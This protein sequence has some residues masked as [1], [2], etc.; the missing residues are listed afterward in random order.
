VGIGQGKRVVSHAELHLRDQ[1]DAVRRERSAARRLAI[2]QDE[3]QYVNATLQQ[4]TSLGKLR[5]ANRESRPFRGVPIYP[6]PT[7]RG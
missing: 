1:R 6:S 2:C 5:L 4:W 7:G 3:R